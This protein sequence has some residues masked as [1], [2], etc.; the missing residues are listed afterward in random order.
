LEGKPAY[1][2]PDNLA[3]L[4]LARAGVLQAG[5][6]TILSPFDPLISDRARAQQLFGF[7]YQLEC[8]LPA[9]K[10]KYGYFVLPI[11]RNGSLVGRLDAKARR[12]EKQLEVIKL[13]LEEGIPPEEAL[14][15]DLADTLRAYA[16]WQGLNKV[17]ISASEP[18]GAAAR[19][20]ALLAR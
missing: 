9:S 4:E 11:L 10:R 12:K 20:N 15:A 7:D 13:Y 17:Q 8:Y 3:L 19:L 6:T 5:L 14:L 1:V 18:P 2:H 16:A